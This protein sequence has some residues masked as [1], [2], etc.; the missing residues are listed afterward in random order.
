MEQR[1]FLLYPINNRIALTVACE[2]VVGVTSLRSSFLPSGL[3]KLSIFGEQI[4]FFM[5]QALE[6]NAIESCLRIPE[7]NG[8]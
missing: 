1:G 2:L 6:L 7:A 5:R 3:N 4:C 8:L